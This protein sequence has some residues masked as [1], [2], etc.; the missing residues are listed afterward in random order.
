MHVDVRADDLL[1]TADGAVS[2]IDWP[3]AAR[4]AAWVDTVLFAVD[5]AVHGGVDPELLVADSPVVSGAD[6]ADVTDLLLAL[7]GTEAQAVRL[8][9]PPGLPTVRDLQRRF[10][11]AAL[12]WARRRV[13]GGLARPL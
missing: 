13:D 1:V 9:P 6:P 11:D 10:H 8:P 7:T 12:A 2:V 4:G 3:G 5:P